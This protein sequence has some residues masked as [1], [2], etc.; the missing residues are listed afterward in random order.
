MLRQSLLLLG[1][2]G[3]GAL[4]IY[5]STVIPFTHDE[6]STWL[7]YRHINVWSCISNWQCWGTANNHW[8]NTALLQASASIFGEKAWALRLPNVVAGILYLTCAAFMCGRYIHNYA[9]K[10]AGFL[11]LCAH[12]YLLDFFSLARGYGLM[13]CGVMW[14]TYCFLRYTEKWEQKWLLFTVI[15]LLFAVLGNFTGLLPWSAMGLAWIILIIANKKYDHLLR[16]GAYWL[17]SALVLLALLYYPVKT[18]SGSGEFEW[19]AQGITAMGVDLMQNLLYGVRYFG[20]NT[21]LFALFLMLGLM[22]LAFFLAMVTRQKEARKVFLITLLLLAANVLVIFLLQFITDAQPPSGRKSI[23]LIPVVFS[24][25]VAGL[26]VLKN[27]GNASFAGLILSLALIG[28][29]IRTLPFAS[30]REWYYDAYYPELLETIFPE[31]VKKDSVLLGS[32]WIFHPALT[33]YQ[34]TTP[35][36]LGGL[37]YQR[38]LVPDSAMQ[39]YF[40]EPSDTSGLQSMGFDLKKHIGPFLLYR[41]E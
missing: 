31:N 32:S 26:G 22:A 1:V 6:A 35:L 39:Y 29:L 18:L 12:T 40:V 14:A 27:T 4:I 28:H 23:Y 20:D 41:R 19:G 5:R 36:P 34:Q 37:A 11:L 24:V 10:L 25:F 13:A 15:S 2:I 30:V 17:G 7:N 33:Y 21:Y 16:H 38:P 3:I 8:L 9:L